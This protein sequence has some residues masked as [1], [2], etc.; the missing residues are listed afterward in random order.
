MLLVYLLAQQGGRLA[1]MRLLLAG[2]AL[3]YTLQ[4][5]TSYLVLRSTRPGGGVEGILAWLAGSLATATWDDL[6]VPSLVLLIVV[7]L[8]MLQARSLNA[9]LA[10][11]ETAIGLGINVARFRLQLFV[12]TSL[13]IGVVVSVS[14]A[15]GFIGLMIPHIG[16]FFVGADHRRLLPLVALGGGTYLI[17]VAPGELPVG[18]VTEALGGPFFLWLLLQRRKER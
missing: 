15:I 9:L 10:G 5:V 7:V 4:A 1:P 17:L 3:G 13:L 2:V 8:L 18:I 12:L 6:G 14:G 16:R 11:E